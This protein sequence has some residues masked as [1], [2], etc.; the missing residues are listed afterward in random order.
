MEQH[1][2][3][4]VDLYRRIF[5]VERFLYSRTKLKNKLSLLIKNSYNDKCKGFLTYKDFFLKNYL[6]WRLYSCTAFSNPR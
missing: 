1:T 2:N 5:F 3:Q 6:S 4:Q